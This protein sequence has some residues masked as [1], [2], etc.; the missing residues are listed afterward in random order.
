LHSRAADHRKLSS[1]RP[2][3]RCGL[4]ARACRISQQLQ[5]LLIARNIVRLGELL[6][7]HDRLH[8]DQ[9]VVQPEPAQREHGHR[10]L[11]RDDAEFERR[12]PD[13][14]EQP[15]KLAGQRRR[16]HDAGA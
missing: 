10:G 16:R 8:D 13:D 1:D 2:D 4:G 9:V 7:P 12:Q 15:V 5:V 14:G 6:L 11:K 3:H